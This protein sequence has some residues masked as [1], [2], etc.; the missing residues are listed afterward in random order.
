MCQISAGNN[1]MHLFKVNSDGTVYVDNEYKGQST[2]QMP[3]G[4]YTMNIFRH[5]S[6][7]VPLSTKIYYCKIFDNNDNLVFDG[8]PVRKNGIGYMYDKV[9]KRLF[10]NNGTGNFILG[11]IK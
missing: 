7:K 2:T 3:D 10:G 8:V 11:P 1:V 9:T 5:S 4:D 6:N